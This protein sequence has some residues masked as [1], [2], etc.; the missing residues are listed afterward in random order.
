V[1]VAGIGAGHPERSPPRRTADDQADAVSVAL[2]AR[3]RTDAILT[4]DRR[5]FRAMHPLTP[6]E[7]FR[8]LPDDL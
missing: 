5:D 1:S 4:L 7:S 6:H 8:L 2:A 3:Y